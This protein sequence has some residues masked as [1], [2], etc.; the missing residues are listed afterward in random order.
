MTIKPFIWI[1]YSIVLLISAMLCVGMLRGF[2]QEVISL[3]CW[4]VGFWVSL[5]FSTRVAVYLKSSI[6]LENKRFAVA[7]I[8]LFLTTILSG[9]VLQ[10]LFQKIIK[11]SYQHTIFMERLGGLICGG[12]QG[13]VVITLVVFLALQTKLPTCLWWQESS[14]LPSFQLLTVWLHNHVITQTATGS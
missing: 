12:M 5:H 4:V 3:L 6:S 2:S 1:D 7:F 10:H 8:G 14:L 9:S 11:Q 13:I